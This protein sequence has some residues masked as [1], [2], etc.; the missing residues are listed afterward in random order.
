M[1]QFIK[2][3]SV[4]LFFT[5]FIVVPTAVAE[6]VKEVTFSAGAPLVNYQASLIIPILTEAFKRNGIKFNAHYYPSLRS[7]MMSNSGKSDGELHRVYDFHQLSAGKY[8][9]LIRIESKLLSVSL[10]VFAKKNIKIE[11][12][13]DLKAYTAV[14]YRGRKDVEILLNKLLPPEMIGQATTDT[15]AFKILSVGAVDVVISESSQAHK[16]IAANPKFS[17]IVEITTLGQSEIYAYIHKKHQNLAP[18]IAKTIDAMKADGSFS[19]LVDE[20]A[21]SYFKLR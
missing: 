21:I 4:S 2:K 19:M 16:I 6:T 8:S 12:L 14:Y 15:Q 17:D 10:A 1:H 18:K 11:N 9:N 13:D 3:K 20:A 5:L 7:L